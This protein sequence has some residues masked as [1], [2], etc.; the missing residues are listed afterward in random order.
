MPRPEKRRNAAM[1]SV[2][3]SP[4]AGIFIVTASERIVHVTI[5]GRVQGVGFRAFVEHEAAKRGLRGWVR[6][7]RN[8]S[9]EAV[10]AGSSDAVDDM[11]AACRRGPRSSR[12]DDVKT[13]PT[14]EDIEDGFAVL[15]TI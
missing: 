1:A 2:P 6:N 14:G 8:G 15:S 13:V 5:T 9:V 12:V 7:R 11:L 3:L 4:D 10:F